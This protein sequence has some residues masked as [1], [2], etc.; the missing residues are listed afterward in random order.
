MRS[1]HSWAVSSQIFVAF[2]SIDSLEIHDTDL[3]IPKNWIFVRRTTQ[4]QRNVRITDVESWCVVW[5]QVRMLSA[6]SKM[7][8][9]GG[10]HVIITPS[11]QCYWLRKT[12]F[13]V[14]LG[15]LEIKSAKRSPQVWPQNYR[16]LYTTK[17]FDFASYL[18]SNKHRES[19]WWQQLFVSKPWS[20]GTCR[21]IGFE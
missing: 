9:R 10:W 14:G 15:I 5:W 18:C 4:L 20:N 3:N 21:K 13:K 2:I 12:A 7:R 1:V 16:S 6:R 17:V 19:W 11:T 8:L